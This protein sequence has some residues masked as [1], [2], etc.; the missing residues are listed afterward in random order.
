VVF[1]LVDGDRDGVADAEADAF[2]VGVGVDDGDAFFVGVG[3]GEGFFVGVGDGDGFFV[4]VGDGDG[5]FVGVG[6]GDGFFVGVGDG[7]GFF[8]GDGDGE[9]LGL[10]DVE[11]G[12]REPADGMDPGLPEFALLAPV[13]V[14]GAGKP[15]AGVTPRW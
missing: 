13:D 3:D 1:G 12:L 14:V 9:R 2:F 8:V 7:D 15:A 4:G 11:L 5:F 6:D 10:G